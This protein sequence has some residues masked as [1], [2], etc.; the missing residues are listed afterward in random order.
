MLVG[1][2][3]KH[4]EYHAVR[5]QQPSNTSN[6][7]TNKS[8]DLGPSGL[9]NR[10]KYK[11]KHS[12]PICLE[13]CFCSEFKF[14][15]VS[16]EFVVMECDGFPGDCR[17]NR[18]C[19]QYQ[20]I[21]WNEYFRPA[22]W[23]ESVFIFFKILPMLNKMRSWTHQADEGECKFTLLHIIVIAY[24]RAC[25]RHKIPFRSDRNGRNPI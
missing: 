14:S 12:S 16:V 22:N 15:I 24:R 1:D 21:W 4:G 8:T 13:N 10:V 17:V 7:E 5:H 3:L 6:I 19:V 20:S 9:H 25:H 18:T 2:N 23:H 11:P